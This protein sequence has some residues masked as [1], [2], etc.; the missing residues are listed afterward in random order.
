MLLQRFTNYTTE[1][2]LLPD[3]GEVL[4]AVSGG[5]DS[6]AMLDLFVRAKQPFAVAHCNFHLRG[7][8]SDRD[9]S[10]VAEAA[11][12][13]GVRFHTVDF[14]T[15]TEAAAKGE[16]IEEAARRLRYE[17]FASLCRDYAYRSVATAHHADDSIETFFLNLFRGTGIRGLHGIRP[18]S[19]LHL[20]SASLAVIRPMLC[21]SRAEID[22]YVR[23]RAIAYVDDRTNFELDARRNRLRLQLLPLLRELYPSFD[24][25][26]TANIERLHDAS[27]VYGQCVDDVRQSLVKP[28]RPS[29]ATAPRD[30]VAINAASLVALRPQ[31]TLA[32][33]LLAPYGFNVA[34]VGD[35]LRAAADEESGRTFLS[36]THKAFL[37][38]GTVVVAPLDGGL[39]AGNGDS[40]G[41]VAPSFFIRHSTYEGPIVHHSSCIYVD[42]A[43]V[44]GTPHL[45]RWHAGDRFTPFGMKGSKL[46]SDFLKDSKLGGFE[47]QHV[48]LLVDGYDRV[49]W[50]VGLRAD[51]R[52]RVDPDTSLVLK[53]E[54]ATR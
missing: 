27:L 28:Y 31:A 10:F 54:V 9:Q 41:D 22:V 8:D 15:R 25:T 47:K 14:D 50:V 1:Q 18:Q 17:W 29:L 40:Q 19:S 12:R 45:R 42:A 32:F 21:F 11:D 48:W 13:L 7:S 2:H 49:M 16:S 23:Q 26:M 43:K 33:E 52:F 35:L 4:L 51:D 34:T 39:S 20:P 3:G 53:Y 37:D 24:A 44:H 5:R 46:V 30:A 38:R 36:P 6:M